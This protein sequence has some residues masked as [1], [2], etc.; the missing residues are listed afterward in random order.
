MHYNNILARYFRYYKTLELINCNYW[1]LCIAKQI[2][3]YIIGYAACQ[4]TK[5]YY[6]RK[7][8]LLNLNKIP[9]AS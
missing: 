2:Q 1:W 5:A 8:A 9:S 3:I 6:E 7:H 4:R